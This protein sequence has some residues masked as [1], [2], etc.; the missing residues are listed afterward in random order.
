MIITV[1]RELWE[2]AKDEASDPLIKSRIIGV[3][4]QFKAFQYLYGVVL[5]ELILKHSNKLSKTFQ[6]P[7]LSASEGQHIA[8]MMVRTLQT[9][10][11]ETQFDLFW[12]KVEATRK[13]FD[14]DEPQ[15]PR[16]RRLPR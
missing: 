10:R 4:A 9:L 3:Q 7:K 12:M 1:L 15:L 8:E 13:E 5:G 2:Q 16:K 11:N 6:S 14:V